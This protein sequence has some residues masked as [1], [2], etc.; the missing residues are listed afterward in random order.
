MI[1]HIF[2]DQKKFS[3]GYFQMLSHHD[4]QLSTMKLVHYG[5]KDGYFKTLG[6][7]TVFIRNF[8]N[9]FTNVKLIRELFRA[10]KVIV[11]S[12]AS[13]YLLLMIILFPSIAGKIY[14]VIWGKDLYFFH[15]LKHIRFYH[16]MYEWLRKKAIRKITKICS[17]FKEDYE[18]ACQWYGVHA[19]NIEMV[20]LYPYALCKSAEVKDSP[21]CVKSNNL[22]ILLGNSASETNN[23]EDVLRILAEHRD[24][25]GQIICPLSYGGNN[26]YVKKIVNIGKQLFG[27]KFH[28]LLEFIPRERYFELINQIDV[29]IYNYDRQEGLGNIWS[30]I[31]S[32]K[33]V[34][35]KKETSTTK[36][37]ERNG[38]V[39]KDIQECRYKNITLLP[40]IL[41]EKN[42]EQLSPL[43]SEEF[44]INKW[45]QIFE[46]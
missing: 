34:Y 15:S 38:I 4:V 24:N 29:G 25:I 14:W 21:E 3:K 5:K 44:S 42:I 30:L 36:F 1:L 12:L 40:E 17:I 32:K 7:D 46:Q 22:I 45:K 16:R 6:L 2:N 20:S 31:L 41:L 37:F 10:Q 27:D 28:P 18:L 33:T 9:P 26:R 11:H 19:E 39:V 8:Y 13:P 43:V 35:M 23:H